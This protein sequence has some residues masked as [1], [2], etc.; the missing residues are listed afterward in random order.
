MVL[1]NDAEMSTIK[2][3]DSPTGNTKNICVSNEDIVRKLC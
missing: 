2:I 3:S 1:R